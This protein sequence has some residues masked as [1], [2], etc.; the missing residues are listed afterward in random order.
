MERSS[1]SN[2]DAE[3]K[4]FNEEVLKNLKPGDLIKIHRDLYKH[5]AV[6]IGKEEGVEKVIHWDIVDGTKFQRSLLA[7]AIW[8]FNEIKK[9][10]KIAD[11]G[12]A[13]V[14]IDSFWTIVGNSKAE[15]GNNK[16]RENGNIDNSQVVQKAKILTQKS[17]PREQFYNSEH[18]ANWCRY[19]QSVNQT[20]TNDKDD[21]KIK[22]RNTELL[23][24]L[25]KGDLIKF[26][27]RFY[28]HWAVYIGKDDDTADAEPK[29]IHWWGPPDFKT[30]T[31]GASIMK[32]SFWEAA[33]NSEA[34][35]GNE[36]DR[37]KGIIDGLRVAA[38]AAAKH[39]LVEDEVLEET[40]NIL[41]NNCEHFAKWCR[42]EL[43][44]D[45]NVEESPSENHGAC[46]EIDVQRAIDALSKLSSIYQKWTFEN[47]KEKEQLKL[48]R[49]RVKDRDKEVS[50][51]TEK[52]TMTHTRVIVGGIF[53]FAIVKR[54]RSWLRRV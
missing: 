44:D 36:M 53:V 33:G 22:E 45:N 54:I 21:D 10:R 46:F 19:G 13:Q 12:E 4:Q 20:T 51:L 1:N 40:Y 14:R 26:A 6:Y 34:E 24:T 49:R 41:F 17:K 18:F 37:G 43:D 47:L 23:K 16:D 48:L 50:V 31:K 28:Y 38:R 39:E 15:N 2:A 7:K 8:A 9:Y 29:V 27:R 32:T 3:T 52:E 11:G 25:K 30:S 5:W 42:Y 35:K